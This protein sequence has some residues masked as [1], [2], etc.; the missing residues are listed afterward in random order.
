MF[1]LLLLKVEVEEVE[2]ERCLVSFFFP[3]LSFSVP[4]SLDDAPPI[5]VQKVQ[6]R[7]THMPP[8]IRPGEMGRE[9]RAVVVGL[10]AESLEKKNFFFL[11]L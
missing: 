1:S 7:T 4:S 2:R 6:I 8:P 5:P 10:H 11:E 3:F 9:G